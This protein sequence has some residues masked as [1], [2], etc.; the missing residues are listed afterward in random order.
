MLA[1]HGPEG[2]LAARRTGC[3][4]LLP[5]LLLILLLLLLALVLPLP[6]ANK[7]SVNPP[8]QAPAAPI[9]C[10]PAAAEAEEEEEEVPPPP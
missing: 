7:G 5:I 10:L 9:P 4:G 6:L 8:L 2:P 1:P 3:P